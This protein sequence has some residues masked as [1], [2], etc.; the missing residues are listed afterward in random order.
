MEGRPLDEAALVQRAKE[1][2]VDAYRALMRAHEEVAFRVA[3]LITGGSADAE[4]A[5]GDAMGKAFLAL[6]RFRADAAFRPWLLAIVANEARNRRRRAGRQRRVAERLGGLTLRS[7][8]GAAPSP[9]VPSPEDE[10]VAALSH[11]ALFDAVA[12][13]GRA[14]ARSWRCVSSPS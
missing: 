11:R 13:L 9:E 6:G 14:I 12:A 8:G 4:D 10:V 3:V 7:S 1:G 2:D 5:A